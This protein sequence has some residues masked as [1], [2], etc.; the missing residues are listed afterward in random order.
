[1]IER[2][3]NRIEIRMSDDEIKL[4]ETRYNLSTSKSISD[5]VRGQILDGVVVSLNEKKL[6][7][8]YRVVSSIANNVN[9][10]AVRVNSTNNIYADD[11]DELKKGVDEILQQQRYFQSELLKLKH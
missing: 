2:R 8:I 5:F 9:Q 1:M 11:I 6:T 3:K 10:I 7:D 4:L